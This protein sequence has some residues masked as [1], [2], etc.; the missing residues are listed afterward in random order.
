MENNNDKLLRSFLCLNYLVRLAYF[1][2]RSITYC[3]TTIQRPYRRRGSAG[4][5]RGFIKFE[6]RSFRYG[7][8][9]VMGLAGRQERWIW[10][11]SRLWG[12]P[13]HYYSFLACHGNHSPATNHLF[14]PD[15]SEFKSCYWNLFHSDAKIPERR[16]LWVHISAFAI[17]I[18]TLTSETWS[19]VTTQTFGILKNED[20]N[21]KVEDITKALQ[22]LKIDSSVKVTLEDNINFG[23]HGNY[24]QVPQLRCWWWFSYKGDWLF[25]QGASLGSRSVRW[26]LELS[27]NYF[28]FVNGFC[29]QGTHEFMSDDILTAAEDGLDYLQSPLDDLFSFYYTL[30]WAA[31]FH[32]IGLIY[33]I[34]KNQIIFRE[35]MDWAQE[36]SPPWTTGKNSNGNRWKC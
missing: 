3:Y 19:S 22:V 14:L 18:A 20:R 13:K 26:N 30:Q 25:Q 5:H 12:A 11:S 33:L 4:H 15:D 6:F 1:F 16:G 27:W 29:T 36:N 34:Y 21:A 31:V 32:A 17:F 10:P 9:V 2:T 7:H 8:Q 28:D 23:W 24:R 35:A